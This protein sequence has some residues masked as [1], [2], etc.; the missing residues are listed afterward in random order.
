MDFRYTLDAERDAIFL[1][2]GPRESLWLQKLEPGDRIVCCHG[3]RRVFYAD[4]WTDACPLCGSREPL[5]F[6]LGANQLLWR[7]RITQEGIV[8]ECPMRAWRVRERAQAPLDDNSLSEEDALSEEEAP[9]EEDATSEEDGASGEDARAAAEISRLEAEIEH[10]LEEEDAI[11]NQIH[12]S[13]T[14]KKLLLLRS[15]FTGACI[16]AL[17]TLAF[18]LTR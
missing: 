14:Q 2:H 5:Y 4:D 17:L 6:L 18:V 13:E 9:S 8:A 1:R 12:E 10:L 16:F 15:A 7:E 11:Y 3:C